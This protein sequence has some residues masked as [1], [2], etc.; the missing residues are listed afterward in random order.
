MLSE[1][2]NVREGKETMPEK[3]GKTEGKRNEREEDT[4]KAVLHAGVV[5]AC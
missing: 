2:E 1:P 4:G 3:T 5:K